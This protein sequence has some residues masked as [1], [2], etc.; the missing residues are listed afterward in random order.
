ML[1]EGAVRLEVGSAHTLRLKLHGEETEVDAR[2]RHVTPV[3]TS[4]G[5]DRYLVGLEF[6]G[7]E[8][9][10]R[11]RIQTF[12]EAARSPGEAATES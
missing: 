5:I 8:E 9:E 6:V 1:V 12:V 11:R 4:A 10:A 7:I 3:I 2:V